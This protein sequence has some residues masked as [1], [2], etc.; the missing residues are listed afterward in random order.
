MG[1]EPGVLSKRFAGED[2][3]DSERNACLLAKLEGVPW[4]RRAACFKCTIVIASPSGSFHLCVGELRG[5]ITSESKGGYGF[6]YDPVFYL[7]DFGRTMAE[8]PPKKKNKISH[9]AKAADK[10]CQFLHQLEETDWE[11]LPFSGGMV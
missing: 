1:G 10:A 8:F 4:E 7:P 11:S 3:S 6:G 2:A 5:I 9:R